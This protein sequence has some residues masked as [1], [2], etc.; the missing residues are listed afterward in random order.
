MTQSF[1][2]FLLLAAL[3]PAAQA[4]TPPSGGQLAA[5][6]IEVS[7]PRDFDLQ[8]PIAVSTPKGAKIHGSICVAPG[9]RPP[10]AVAVLAQRADLN[11]QDLGSARIVLQK[12]LGARGQRCA[13]YDLQTTW[14]IQS[15]DS[16][17]ICAG[18][19]SEA[20]CRPIAGAD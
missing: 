11:G 7:A 13:F 14:V 1:T 17:R 2:V 6:Q 9:R 18:R 3:A 19:T 20:R 12:H 15:T 16:I 8:R 5:S 10:Y 4:A